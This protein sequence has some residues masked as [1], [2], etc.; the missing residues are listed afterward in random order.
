MF[1]LLCMFIWVGLFLFLHLTAGSLSKWSV[2]IPVS[3]SLVCCMFFFLYLLWSFIHPCFYVILISEC[4]LVLLSVFYA[5]TF[6]LYSGGEPKLQT[7]NSCALQTTPSPDYREAPLFREKRRKGR[8][9]G[10]KVRNRRTTGRGEETGERQNGGKQTNGAEDSSSSTGD[11]EQDARS[12]CGWRS[13]RRQQQSS[14]QQESVQRTEPVQWMPGPSATD[15]ANAED[16]ARRKTGTVVGRQESSKRLLTSAIPWQ[17]PSNTRL[18]PRHMPTPA[19]PSWRPLQRLLTPS[20]ACDPCWLQYAIGGA[21]GPIKLIFHYHKF[22]IW[23]KNVC[24]KFGAV[25]VVKCVQELAYDI[26]VCRWRYGAYRVII[27]ALKNLFIVLGEL[28]EF[29]QNF[30]KVKGVTC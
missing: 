17:R 22:N 28:A 11:R 26:F 15:G 12:Q 3:F 20:D 19:I 4:W 8:T 18:R 2:V 24:M 1:S 30:I 16:A 23:M 25:L 7:E 29:H 6:L 9:D 13:Q 21:V 5:F 27:F 10:R 14:R